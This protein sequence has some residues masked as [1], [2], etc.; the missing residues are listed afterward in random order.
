M[1]LAGFTLRAKA[2][3]RGGKVFLDPTGQEFG[4]ETGPGTLI[5]PGDE[6]ARWREMKVYDWA[7]PRRTRLFIALS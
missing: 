7:D 3:V 1:G 4:V 2:A 5:M 6:P